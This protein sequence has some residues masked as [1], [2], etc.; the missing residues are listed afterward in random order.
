MPSKR[1]EKLWKVVLAIYKKMYAESTP[2]GD[3]DEM[4]KSGETKKKG[5]FDKYHLCQERQDAI[6]AE[7]IKANKWIKK[8]EHQKI[9]TT[10][11]LGSSP[12]FELKKEK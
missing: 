1:E 9:K 10:V 8:W 4:I 7:E 11:Y 12:R 2:T 6:I 5:F 3:I